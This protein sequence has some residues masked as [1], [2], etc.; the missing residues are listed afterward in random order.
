MKRKQPVYT[1]LTLFVAC[2]LLLANLAACQNPTT[3][4]PD[5]TDTPV[6]TLSVPS[7][8]RIP[9]SVNQNATPNQ[10]PPIATSTVPP[11]ATPTV[12]PTELPP[13]T[14][15]EPSSTVLPTDTPGPLPTPTIEAVG[16][17]WLQYANIFRREAD[18][19]PLRED[20]VFTFQS[21]QHS[22]YMSLT[23][24]LRHSQKDSSPYYSSGGQL[25]A[26]NG[27]IAAGFIGSDPFKW[28]I[29]YWISAPFHAIPLLD[30]Q[31]ITTGFAEYRDPSAPTPLTATMDVQRG[32]GPL[33]ADTS[34]PIMY[35]R[36]GG[37]T[38][39][40]RYSLPEFPEALSHC[41]GYQ[42]P[43]GA[44]IILQIGSGDQVPRVQST[45]LLKDG[46]IMAHCHYD[47]TTF[48]HPDAYRQRTARLILDNRDAIVIIPQQPL[49]PDSTY[50]VRID[51][52]D[53]TYTWNF[54]TASGPPN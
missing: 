46:A 41:P 19:P 53:E 28:A 43:T 50:E 25:A 11:T 32:L 34:Y 36:N 4:S 31:L 5:P 3:V 10:P 40:L 23:G 49:L 13:T 39:V 7:P 26:E 8:T 45:T 47:E 48:S 22:R 29:N 12:L 54:R 17:D 51:V 35:P 20:T 15:P 18:L 14:T 33:P 21:G 6:A 2:W 38:W 37:V 24:E 44:P 42:Q 1:L 52:N 30:P 27:N 9:P 16:T